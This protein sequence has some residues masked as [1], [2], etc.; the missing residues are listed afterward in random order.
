MF[1][2]IEGDRLIRLILPPLANLLL[3]GRTVRKLLAG[4]ETHYLQNKKNERAL[5]PKPFTETMRT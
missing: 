5:A 1:T 4:V 2:Y 3:D